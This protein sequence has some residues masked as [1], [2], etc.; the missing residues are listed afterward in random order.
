VTTE[1][2]N[3][4][5]TIKFNTRITTVTKNPSNNK[6]T[7]T[8]ST[9]DTLTTDLYIPTFGIKP[10]TSYMPTQYLDNKGYINVNT[11]FNLKGVKN[12]FAIGDCSSLENSQIITCDRQS[13][14]LS[15]SLLLMLA[16]KIPVAY[17][18]SGK[19]KLYL[20][21]YHHL[22]LHKQGVSQPSPHLSTEWL[23]NLFPF[24]YDRSPNRSQCR[25]G[26]LWYLASP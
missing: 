17:Q 20:S 13:V 12:I 25:D 14:H 19:R 18:P 16:N 9:G 4:N 23:T 6:T 5:V 24:S 1:L 3:L 8:L 26:I 22:L 2:K 21:Y 15:K 7:L 10:N 11:F